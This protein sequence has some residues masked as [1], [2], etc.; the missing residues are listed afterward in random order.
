[1]ARAV[2]IGALLATLILIVNAAR[3][4]YL[5][6]SQPGKC[7]YVLRGAEK[8][9]CLLT[10]AGFEYF[11]R[12]D[13][14]MEEVRKVLYWNDVKDKKILT[15]LWYKAY[16][17]DLF[18]K[19]PSNQGNVWEGWNATAFVEPG[20]L[21][22]QAAPSK[23]GQQV[24]ME[25]TDGKMIT[26]TM[27]NTK[28]LPLL[29][30]ASRRPELPCPSGYHIYRPTKRCFKA[31]L[32]GN[33]KNPIEADKICRQEHAIMGSINREDENDFI[34][35]LQS[36]RG[37]MF[38]GMRFAWKSIKRRFPNGG[39]PKASS[40]P[41]EFLPFIKE[42]MYNI[43]GHPIVYHNFYS[44]QPDFNTPNEFFIVK[45]GDGKWHDYNSQNQFDFF[46]ATLPDQT[47]QD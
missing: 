24:V 45:E 46:C 14:D 4:C 40:P 23:E 9:K 3:D 42:F 25:I 34:A 8:D 39:I 44:S 2:A 36:Q 27:A 26:Y 19:V 32:G 12:S 41:E 33:R 18:F 1:M 17:K 47:G 11:P 13:T 43:D 15:G 5:M 7:I 20:E 31:Y 29:C 38:L 6:P 22:F 21:H 37:S 28:D 30:I 16:D 10:Y 35:T